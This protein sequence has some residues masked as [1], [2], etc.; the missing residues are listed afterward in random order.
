VKAAEVSLKLTDDIEIRIPGDSSASTIGK[1]VVVPSIAA[2]PDAWKH[3]NKLPVG[4]RILDLG[5][6]N[7]V[8]ITLYMREP[9]SL[10]N[11]INSFGRFRVMQYGTLAASKRQK[12]LELRADEGRVGRF[13]MS[14]KLGDRYRLLVAHYI[15][16]EGGKPSNEV[17]AEIYHR[18]N[19]IT[20]ILEWSQQSDVVEQTVE[21]VLSS[22]AMKTN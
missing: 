18:N 16:T 22:L 12:K 3:L 17:M 14:D 4:R 10:A 13:W 21:R 9:D 2:D 6:F 1:K 20:V 8:R 15:W 11:T 7:G 5:S 19:L